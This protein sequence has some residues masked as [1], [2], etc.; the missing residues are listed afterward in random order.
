MSTF[1]TT[2]TTPNFDNLLLQSLL[3]RLQIHQPPPPTTAAAVD[4]HHPLLSSSFEDFLADHLSLSLSS[5]E[6]NSDID[7]DTD[8]DDNEDEG[9][10]KKKTRLSKEESRLEKEI[11]KIIHTGNTQTLNPNSG[12]AVAIGDHYVCV[13]FHEED[14]S[15]YRVWE[16]HGHIML[17][18][19]DLG[20]TPEYVYGNYF[21]RVKKR[22]K[23]EKKVVE[24][25]NLGLRELIDGDDNDGVRGLGKTRVLHRGRNAGSSSNVP[26]G[27]KEK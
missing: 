23:E 5:D 11:I 24:N 10:E 4:N 12:Q 14:G 9:G 3:N 27:T 25:C 15:G 1:N 2:A 13:G 7:N 8:D 6:N 17:F 16:W 21:E 20:Y 18:D 19:D 22:E 26:E